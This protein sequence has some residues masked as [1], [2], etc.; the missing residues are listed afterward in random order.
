MSILKI[1]NLQIGQFSTAA[2]NFTW[3][4]PAIPDGT[5][6]FGNGNA[7]SVTDLVT[8]TSAGNLGI[9]TSSPVSKLHIDPGT[10]MT[11]SGNTY[12]V[13]IA[14]TSLKTYPSTASF[15]VYPGFS[16]NI[17]LGTSQT[18]D[19]TTPGGFNFVYGLRNQLTKSAGSTSDIE[20]LYFNGIQNTLT[21]TDLNTCKQYVGLSDTFNYRGIDA[22]GRISSSF[23]AQSVSLNAPAGGTQTISNIAANSLSISNANANVTYNITSATGWA[24]PSV[25]FSGTAGNITATIGSYTAFG[26]SPFWGSTLSGAS[27]SATITNFYGL[28]LP[29]P[30]SATNLTI[31]N[32]WGVYADDTSANNYFGGNVGIGTTTP[33]SKLQV[34][35]DVNATSFN[36]GQLAGMR[37]RIINGAMMIDQR[38]AGTLINPAVTSYTVDR[39]SYYQSQTSKGTIG[40]NAGSITP[41]PGFTNYL[42]FTS[43]SSYSLTATDQFLL[44]QPIE[45]YNTAD[46]AWGTSNAKT[47]ALSFWVYSSLTGTFG[48]SIQ[49]SAQTRCY[50]FSYSVASANTWAY[51]TVVI[52]GDTTGTWLTNN[53]AGM[54]VWFSFGTGST[55][56]GTAGAWS[57]SSYLT[58]VPGAV[59]V[60]GTNGATFY[61]TGVQLEKGAT[62]T[63]FENRL[64]GTELALCQRYYEAI[65][66]P[67][68][69]PSVAI[70]Y[71][72]NQVAVWAWQFQVT[73]RASPT[74]TGSTSSRLV[75]PSNIGGSGGA[76]V[77]SIINSYAAQLATTTTVS[78]ASAGWVD[79]Y[80]ATASAEL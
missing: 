5:V 41:P 68:S 72:T 78:T 12:G 4:Q 58:S 36:G 50:P 48:G 20:R 76:V 51:I 34:V 63:P 66:V 40:Q 33:T 69:M 56:S 16:Q 71:S 77:S 3:Y 38:N 6:R 23:N 60:V 30:S 27:S 32:R 62:A 54:R 45:G 25:A 29:P 73:K 57:G 15:S 75:F 10:A 9:G 14:N 13:Y 44:S 39:W 74:V 61:I 2:N 1:N 47:V 52:P 26:M 28:R 64:Y 35:G 42:G 31:T 49:N 18:I 70:A 7:G 55:Y 8:L 37:N 79:N 65:S 43:T 46:L 22:N 19:T 17:E 59:S 80:S 53:G 21:W 11:T 67:V 24:A